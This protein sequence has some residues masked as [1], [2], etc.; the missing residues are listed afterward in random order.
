MPPR[1]L[2]SPAALAVLGLLAERARHP[3]ELKTILRERGLDRTL[4]LKQATLYDLLPRLAAAGL[5]TQDDPASAGN[6]PQRTVYRITTAGITALR[7]WLR[8]LLA[9]PAHDATA[10][11]AALA[12][13]FALSRSEVAELVS[14]RAAAIDGTVA[15]VAAGLAAAQDV[16]PVFLTDHTY[17]Q[18]LR[19]AERD[20]L[21]AF[22]ADLRG[23]RL[24]WPLEDQEYPGDDRS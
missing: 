5:V 6:R 4:G 14:R 22:V 16:P 13:M 17:A 12:F 21:R 7:Q 15:E 18:A 9:D 24:S 11:A 3:Y 8:E 20:W 19:R 23:G 2:P 10:F 1:P